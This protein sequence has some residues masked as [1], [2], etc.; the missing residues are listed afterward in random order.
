MPPD[1]LAGRFDCH[2]DARIHAGGN[3]LTRMRLELVRFHEDAF[4]K[5]WVAIAIRTPDLMRW[6]FGALFAST[7]RLV[8]SVFPIDRLAL[9]V[10]V[11]SLFTY[12]AT[13]KGR[14]CQIA[15][16][17]AQRAHG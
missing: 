16:L 5:F 12:T 1:N 8:V 3:K 2:K 13:F 10:A 17:A 9:F 7:A 15:W 14:R 11:R 4:F 6:V